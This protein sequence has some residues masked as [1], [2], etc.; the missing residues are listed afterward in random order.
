[1]LEGWCVGSEA[2]TKEALISSI[3]YLEKEED[4]NA[5]WRTYVNTKLKT[6]YQDI[7]AQINYLIMLKAP[8]FSS[9][10]H[11]RKQQEEQLRSTKE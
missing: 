2:Q 6:E 11:W 4:P 3:N 5:V 9:V 8:N 7:F 1:M 10:Y